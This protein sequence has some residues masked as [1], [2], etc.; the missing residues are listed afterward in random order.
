VRKEGRLAG[1]LQELDTWRDWEGH[2]RRTIYLMLP[3]H[4]WSRGASHGVDIWVAALLQSCDLI[5]K[6]DLEGRMGRQ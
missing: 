1:T 6:G 3:D 5:L 2:H 4:C